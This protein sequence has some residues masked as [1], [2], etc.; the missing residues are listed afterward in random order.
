M[1]SE[2]WS[3][4]A[5]EDTRSPVEVRSLGGTAQP[6]DVRADAPG[7]N[8]FRRHGDMFM[9]HVG[10]KETYAL[11]VPD[12]KPGDAVVELFSGKRYNAAPLSLAT[13]IPETW[14]FRI[15]RK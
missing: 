5:R 9:F 13:S 7:G 11:Q 3:G 8:Y 2:V 1:K 6:S 14:L 4:E 10:A 15:E 12:L